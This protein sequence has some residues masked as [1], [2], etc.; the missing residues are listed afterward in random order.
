MLLSLLLPLL[1]LPLLRSL[2]LLASGVE[3]IDHFGFWLREGRRRE[4][5]EEK[6]ER[7]GDDKIDSDVALSSLSSPKGEREGGGIRPDGWRTRK[8]RKEKS[9]L[10]PSALLPC[11]SSSHAAV[12]KEGGAAALT[13]KKNHTRK[14]LPFSLFSMP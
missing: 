5:P 10:P 12:E 13:R 14:V 11:F 1:L 6:E 8:E 2:L 3:G 4:R 7:G 9:F